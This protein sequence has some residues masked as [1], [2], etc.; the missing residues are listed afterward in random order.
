MLDQPASSPP[1]D[2]G[3]MAPSAS[4]LDAITERGPQIFIGV[5]LLLI[6]VGAYLAGADTLTCGR[7]DDRVNYQLQTT[8]I[9][10]WVTV[11][12]RDIPDVV[13]A[14]VR[15]TQQTGD[16]SPGVSTDLYLH[17]RGNLVIRTLGGG[18]A[19]TYAGQ[20]DGLLNRRSTAPIAIAHSTWIVAGACAG[21]GLV[22]LAFGAAARRSLATTHASVPYEATAVKAEVTFTARDF[23]E[24][25][26]HWES[27]GQVTTRG[28]T[29]V[30][31]YQIPQAHPVHLTHTVRVK[32]TDDDG[33]S[34]PAHIDVVID[35]RPDADGPPHQPR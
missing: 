9:L 32:L 18:E 3:R 7:E 17:T 12:R 5:G 6:L 14:E 20:V 29:A 1:A 27:D 15:V 34:A 24:P 26:A 30:I 2:E 23:R 25:Q 16:T 13:A 8:R 35:S 4:I 19:V 33:G 11:E 10:G 31:T 28:H 21:F 22:F